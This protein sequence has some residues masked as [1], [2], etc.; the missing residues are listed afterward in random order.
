MSVRSDRRPTS[1]HLA[2]RC[3]CGCTR[4]LL[5]LA[6]V[7]AQEGLLALAVVGAQEGLLA[8]A[9]VGAQD[10]LLAPLT[11]KMVA[12]GFLLLIMHNLGEMDSCG[13]AVLGKVVAGW[14][15]LAI[16]RAPLGRT[17][18]GCPCR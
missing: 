16:L 18:D 17:K 13:D 11:V 4:G 3:S 9:V 14:P 15:L 5:A 8:L 1:P 6:V 10:G 2:A 7:G 12:A